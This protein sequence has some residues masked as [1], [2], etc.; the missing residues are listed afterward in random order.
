ML[1]S[2]G[3]LSV[4]LKSQKKPVT[5]ED[6]GIPT[7]YEGLTSELVIDG[8]IIYKNLRQNNLDE[9]WLVEEM[10]RQGIHSPK[11]SCWLAWTP[12]VSCMWTN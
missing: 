5:R 8:E 4:L 11:E 7:A 6:L 12:R 9:T 10:E 3:Q 1:E 2:N